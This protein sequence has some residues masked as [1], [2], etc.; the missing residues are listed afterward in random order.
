M[1]KTIQRIV[2]LRHWA[3]AAVFLALSRGGA[4]GMAAGQTLTEQPRIIRAEAL[5]GD[6][7]GVALQSGHTILLELGSR[8]REP[9]FAAL[10]ES[11]G[12]CK[13]YTDGKAICWPGGVSIALEELLAMLLSCGNNNTV[14]KT[15]STGGMNP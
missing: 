6:T 9:A 5:D 13:P 10:I 14:T 8:I 3:F 12:F 2:R 7:V 11:G 1:R 4:Y 15:K